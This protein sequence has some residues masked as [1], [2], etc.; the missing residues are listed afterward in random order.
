MDTSVKTYRTNMRASAA[1]RDEVVS[2]A[3]LPFFQHNS[4]IFRYTSVNVD[5]RKIAGYR[6]SVI[7]VSKINNQILSHCVG[8]F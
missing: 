7:I 4:C 5:A 6:A 1:A 2:R 8:C 3:C